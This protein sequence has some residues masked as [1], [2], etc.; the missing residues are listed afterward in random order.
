MKVCLRSASGNRLIHSFRYEAVLESLLRKIFF[1][2][3]MVCRADMDVCMFPC[4]SPPKEHSADVG[5]KGRKWSK[6]VKKK[7]K[8]K[9]NS[10]ELREPPFAQIGPGS[11][12]ASG[13]SC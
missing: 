2:V 8:G 11:A 3:H 5:G 4:V 7:K 13:R 1:P 6:G 9:K 10:C 12:E